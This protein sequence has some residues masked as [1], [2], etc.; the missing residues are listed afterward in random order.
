VALRAVIFDYG[1]TLVSFD[2]PHA[3]L[4]DVLRQV[5]PWLGPDVPDAETLMRT[6]LVPLEAELERFGEDEVHWMDLYEGAWRRAGIVAPRATLYR[7]LDLEQQVWDRHVQ[8]AEGALETLRGLRARGLKTAV[9]SNAPF[10]P[11]MMR[12]QMRFNQIGDEL[13][14]VVMSAEVGKRKPARELYLAALDL[15]SVEPG[16]ALYVGDRVQ[17]DYEGARAVG[18]EAVICT[19]LARHAPPDGVP[20][21]RRLTDLLELV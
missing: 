12:R 18:M 19:Q 17:E 15:L 14:V 4:L 11:E 10:P 6:V 21:I 20:T 8:V 1:L 2:Y 16:E 5:R 9:A 3:E 13:D 7:V